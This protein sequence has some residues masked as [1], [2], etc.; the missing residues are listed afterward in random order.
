[1]ASCTFD[2][3]L[4]AMR[5]ACNNVVSP[6]SSPTSGSNSSPALKK[7]TQDTANAKEAFEEVADVMGDLEGVTEKYRNAILKELQ[8]K[9]DAGKSS[10]TEEQRIRKA[11]KMVEKIKQDADAQNYSRVKNFEDKM[12][13]ALGS[14]NL[15]SSTLSQQSKARQMEMNELRF[16][17]ANAGVPLSKFKEGIIGTA[18]AFRDFKSNI[19]EGFSKV[20]KFGSDFQTFFSVSNITSSWNKFLGDQV[21]DNEYA[22]KDLAFQT[23]QISKNSDNATKNMVTFSNSVNETG[24]S[25]SDYRKQVLALARSGISDIQK[26][27]KLTKSQLF[28]EKQLGLQA[29]ELQETFRSMSINM[30]MSEIQVGKMA[31]S[32]SSVAKSSGLT[33]AAMKDVVANTEKTMKLF[34]EFRGSTGDIG[35]NLA[36]ANAEA[37]KLGVEDTM[38][39]ITSSFAGMTYDLTSGANQGMVAL[40]QMAAQY[41]GGAELAA[42]ALDGTMA[43]SEKDMKQFAIGFEKTLSQQIGVNSLKDIDKLSVQQRMIANQTMKAM[44]GKS[45]DEMVKASNAMTESYKSSTEKISDMNKEKAKIDEQLANKAISAERRKN[46]EAKKNDLDKKIAEKNQDKT[47]E[48]TDKFLE[49]ADSNKDQASIQAA[50][51]E[52]FD[53]EDLKSK[54]LS[55]LSPK[56]FGEKLSQLTAQSGTELLNQMK[57]LKI[58]SVGEGYTAED[59][60]KVIARISSGKAEKG[61]REVM[62]ELQRTVLTQQRSN[63]TP[64]AKLEQVT[65]KIQEDL[66]RTVLPK[67][68]EAL[69]ALMPYIQKFGEFAGKLLE[70]VASNPFASMA[71]ALAPFAA[72]AAA[73]VASFATMV[74]SIA[75][76]ALSVVMFGRS[77]MGMRTGGIGGGIGGGGIDGAGGKGVKGKGG[78][79]VKGGRGG[80]LGGI[81]RGGGMLAGGLG[82][83]LMVANMAGY[84]PIAMA[85]EGLGASEETAETVSNVGTYGLMGAGVATELAT[86]KAATSAATT[87]ATKTTEK[88]ATSAATKVGTSLLSKGAATVAKG[89]SKLVPGLGG[90]VSGGME[91]AESGSVGRAVTKG[92]LSTLGSIAGGVLTGGFGGQ[93]VGAIAGDWIGDRLNDLGVGTALDKVGSAV[94]SVAA[95]IGSV[96]SSAA[97]GI[98]SGIKGAGSS[99]LG[100]IQGA[101]S[102]LFGGGGGAAGATAGAAGAGTAGA[103]AGVAGASLS[104]LGPFGML[105]D[106]MLGM[107]SSKKK[108]AGKTTEKTKEEKI[109]ELEQVD[110]LKQIL[111]IMKKCC[112]SNISE[113][114]K[115]LLK[116]S[117]I[118]KTA[119]EGAQTKSI[120]NVLLEP[121]DKTI[122]NSKKIFDNL[123]E[124][125]NKMLKDMGKNIE[126]GSKGTPLG[127][128]ID[129]ARSTSKWFSGS[130][131]NSA[132]TVTP[133]TTANPVATANP[134]GLSGYSD[135]FKAQMAA[136]TGIIT[137]KKSFSGTDLNSVD[138]ELDKQ[139]SIAGKTLLVLQE[140][141][142]NLKPAQI[143][144]S[145][146][147]NSKSASGTGINRVYDTSLTNGNLRSSVSNNISGGAGGNPINV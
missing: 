1:M 18:L 48:I 26:A 84:D 94:G 98:W 146:V 136:Q 28:L 135:S 85:A 112:V 125:I 132:T 104:S 68:T 119:L 99:I 78:K 75:G 122:K 49:L 36:K 123:P 100:G 71:L 13:N 15:F 11:Y 140:I 14:F 114:P 144:S 54:G 97:G 138:Q 82:A 39:E 116:T 120:S 12:K 73:L 7:A 106:G 86:K 130:K 137:D 142:N 4:D 37:K 34:K 67:L 9:V 95:G 45:L 10:L 23:G 30:N 22:L 2:E 143:S 118:S 43:N 24:V 63:V 47:I 103:A 41:G 52:K 65:N 77:V 126:E 76:F 35:V 92:G 33:G 129:I 101:G 50:M 38:N 3:F 108:E 8:A 46:L 87:V 109:K 21:V 117:E 62:L 25:I 90:I 111:E 55:G 57:E 19:T 133:A 102:W 96:A 6:S 93:A 61:D 91:Y 121:I 141:N 128:A 5:A 70:W 72:G 27:E 42:K 80:R 31:L 32:L 69:N 115:E 139:T 51:I 64:T 53:A 17:A 58:N 44:Y 74:A 110:V 29:G 107:F 66:A 56:E 145:G 40:R 20:A 131:E 89:A 79:V 147:I 81:A 88:A 134:V 83:G 113:K 16:A 124:P 59:I 127:T 60:E 105:Y